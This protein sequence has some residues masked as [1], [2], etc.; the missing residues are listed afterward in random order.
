[1]TYTFGQL[2]GFWTQA[3]GPSAVAPI[4]A[5]IAM[6]ESSGSDVI[7]QGQPYSTT[8][9]GLW[10]ITPGNS[11]PSIGSDNALLNPETNAKAAVAKFKQAGNSFNPWTTYTSGGYKNF[12][13]SGVAATDTSGY[14]SSGSGGGSTASYSDL[15]VG[16]VLSQASGLLK[17]VATVLD[18]TFGMFGKGQGWRF[19]FTLI[20][21]VALYGSYK[22]LAGPGGG[23]HLPKVVPIPI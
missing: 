16:G 6:A 7:Q 13:Q 14:T 11:E 3:G 4:A 17:D 19:A 8:G 9:W 22:V 10:Q 2:E 21:A 20:A 18:Y 12:M 15:G 23:P 5:A 1:M